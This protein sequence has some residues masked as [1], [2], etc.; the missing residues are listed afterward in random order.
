[1]REY[2]NEKSER[3]ELV[4]KLSNREGASSSQGS[5]DVEQLR[6]LLVAKKDEFLE[7]Q[8]ECTD[9]KLANIQLLNRAK[10]AEQKSQDLAK[11]VEEVDAGYLKFTVELAKTGEELCQAHTFK[12]GFRKL[13]EMLEAQLLT[14]KDARGKLTVDLASLKTRCDRC[15]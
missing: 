1:M 4:R 5:S 12:E 6:Y 3:Q 9:L 10:V 13:Y 7:S 11:H 15:R 2:P 14:S 8:R